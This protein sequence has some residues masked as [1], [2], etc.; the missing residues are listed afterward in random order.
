[1][2]GA[3]I[4]SAHAIESRS[5][6]QDFSFDWAK[7]LLELCMNVSPDLN[8]MVKSG[9][10][11]FPISESLYGTLK[12]PFNKFRI[13]TQIGA[14]SEFCHS[15]GFQGIRIA[16]ET[17]PQLALLQLLIDSPAAVFHGSMKPVVCRF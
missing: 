16:E 11:K 6:Q 8:R 3:S 10:N 15:D 14:T 4:A 5:P 13:I 9:S 1:V 12:H 2:T 7:E 17:L